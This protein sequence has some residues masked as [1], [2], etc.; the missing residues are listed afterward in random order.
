MSR[1]HN[2]PRR[3][4]LIKAVRTGDDGHPVAFIGLSA[5]N[6]VRLLAKEPILVDLKELGFPGGKVA[7]L[8]GRTEKVIAEDLETVGLLPQGATAAMPDP[9]PGQSFFRRYA[10]GD[11]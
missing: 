2:S 9:E 7:I 10:A 4:L 1:S 8:G 5:E 3:I 6:W 11:D